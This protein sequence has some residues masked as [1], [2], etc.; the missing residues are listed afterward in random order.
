[1]QDP[2]VI[3]VVGA[4][5]MGA[6]IAQKIAQEGF[7]TL[8][9]DTDKSRAEAGR[10][11]IDASLQ[12]AVE[13][14]IL[15]PDQAADVL[16]RVEAVGSLDELA[17]A[18][19]VIEAIF[20]DLLAKKSLFR[21][22]DEACKEGCILATNTSSF[23]VSE[24]AS[25]THRPGL[26]VG[27]HYFFHPAKNRLL[28]VV[29]GNL[30]RP[31]VVD[32]MERFAEAHGKTAI[33][34]RDAPGF[35][36][37]RFFVPWLNEAVRVLE[38]GIANIPSI[39]AA[40]KRAFGIGM[41]PFELMNIT[42]VPVSLHAASTLGRELGP[43]YEPA[44][45]LATQVLETKAD[46]DLSGSVDEAVADQVSDRLMAAT[47]A[48]VGAL[49]DEG[50]CSLEDIDRGARIG[51][52]W[53]RGPFELLNKV[54]P[55]RALE[56]VEELGGTHPD[57]SIPESLQAQAESNEPFQFQRVDLNVVDGIGHIRIN[58][59]EVLNA[60]DE[61]VVG[62]LAERL[63]EALKTEGLRGI[64]LEGA[65]KAFVA[66]ADI[67]FF[68]RNIE[69]ADIDRIVA[70]TEA[71]QR[72][73]RRIE[74]A[75]VPVVARVHGMALG[76]G[77]ELALACHAIVCSHKAS[78]S[79]PETGIG[80]YPG[81]GG[82]QRL[83]RIVGKPLARRL[84]FTGRPLR[85]QDAVESGLALE[86]VPLSELD[87]TISRWIERGLP[88]H[89]ASPTG[90]SAA[91]QEAYGDEVVGAVLE[92][93]VPEG[94]SEDARSLLEKDLRAIARKA[95]VAL[96]TASELIDSGADRD[97]GSAL[98][99][100]LDAL[101]GI[102]GTQDALLGLRSVGSRETPPWQGM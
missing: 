78:F 70:F 98:Q 82:T 3:A 100:E 86:A 6:G 42:G 102:F 73:L 48:V 54:G 90:G 31:D 7:R 45:L 68:V 92:G 101:A 33:Q 75:P 69:A 36:V 53:A 12:E 66:G 79:L 35:A 85:A 43:F 67:S 2:R 15:K 20:E 34:T 51:L 26:V 91:E 38:E 59:P 46:W 28:E 24:L 62:Q 95:P 44:D 52:R 19:L 61:E 71:G 39:E 57:L 58:R 83:Q 63:E 49:I 47:F 72:L 16:S 97:L 40:A 65:G 11:R 21:S 55:A 13:R 93:Q 88:D 60:L 27:L 74:T 81:L 64:V 14:R 94:V 37:N 1:M 18:D 30:T 25:V 10:A 9:A 29:P 32:A 76:G 50:V 4:G 77:V 89:Y 99:L 23:Y 8:I 96:K 80:I 56:L 84:I 22:L 17:D 41:G 5:N 87:S